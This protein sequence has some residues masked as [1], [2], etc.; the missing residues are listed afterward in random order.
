MAFSALGSGLTTERFCSSK[1]WRK[2]PLSRLLLLRS[3]K[4][5]GLVAPFS[6]EMGEGC[7]CCEMLQPRTAYKNHDVIISI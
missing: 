5:F 6:T 7:Q 1:F 4:I 3:H 2:H